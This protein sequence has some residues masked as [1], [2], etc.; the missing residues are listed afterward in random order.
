MQDCFL[1]LEGMQRMHE[2]YIFLKA[3]SIFFFAAAY[4]NS[5]KYEFWMILATLKK[6]LVKLKGYS[7]RS[8]HVSRIFDREL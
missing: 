7:K 6:Y 1:Q 2:C 3:I 5:R 8:S 4:K